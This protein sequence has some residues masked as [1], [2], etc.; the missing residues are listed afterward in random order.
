MPR[1]SKVEAL[2][3]N[4]KAW[5]DETLVD[6]GFGGYEAL[7]ADLKARGYDISKTAVHR[8]GQSFEDRLK[9]LRI[10][11]EQ[12]KAVVQSSP[13]DEDAMSQALQRLAQEKIFTAL[14]DMEVDPS[15]INLASMT[16]SIAELSRASV[17]LKEFAAKARARA[18]AAAEDVANT[19]KKAGLTDEAAEQ[20]RKRILGIAE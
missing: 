15:K 10:A 5:L 14:V 20:I 3:K 1:R 7:A 6:G 11:T 12:A 8:Y 13:D 18:Q 19:V 17:T 2:P 4:V 16:K 9:A